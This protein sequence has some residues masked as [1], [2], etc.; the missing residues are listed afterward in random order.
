MQIKVARY[1]S[2]MENVEPIV[3]RHHIPM[4]YNQFFA[5]RL[6]CGSLQLKVLGQIQLQPLFR[7]GRNLLYAF[8]KRLHVSQM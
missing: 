4:V 8:D 3:Q 6:S 5:H 2:V 7:Q 1:F